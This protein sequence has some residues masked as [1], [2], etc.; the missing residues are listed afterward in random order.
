MFAD[1]SELFAA[2]SGSDAGEG[3]ALH[4]STPVAPS[5]QVEDVADQPPAPAFVVC[6]FA[7][8]GEEHLLE[9]VD[10]LELLVLAHEQQGIGIV[11]PV[12]GTLRNF[13]EQLGVD[14]SVKKVV[15]EVD[16]A[17]DVHADEASGTRGI[18]KGLGLVGGTNER[19]IATV[20]LIG[21][22]VWRTELHIGC[23]EQVFQEDLLTGGGLIEL[24]DIDECKAGEAEVEVSLV[25]EV[26]AI[27]VIVAQLRR[28]E[29]PTK[30]GLATALSSY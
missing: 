18:C 26:D 25:L 8:E 5:Q 19:G 4:G 10:A 17:R 6:R 14:L 3:D 23:G 28:E 29:D 7:E 20:L 27:V 11:E 1:H 9:A 21:L 30:T 15:G 24:V 16:V 2:Q 13:L 22:A 12:A